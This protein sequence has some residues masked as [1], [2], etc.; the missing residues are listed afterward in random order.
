MIMTRIFQEV[1]LNKILF[2][3]NYWSYNF[4]VEPDD[5]DTEDPS[6]DETSHSIEPSM[7]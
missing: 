2:Y 3:K 1:L 4:Y 5:M 7:S 6:S